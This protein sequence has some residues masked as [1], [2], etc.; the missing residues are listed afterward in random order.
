MKNFL[1]FEYI[2]KFNKKF[3]FMMKDNHPTGGA[4]WVPAQLPGGDHKDQHSSPG[5]KR[6]GL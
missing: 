3:I 2:L 4:H 6:A 5:E 1:N